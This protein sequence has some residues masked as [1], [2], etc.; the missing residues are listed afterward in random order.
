MITISATSLFCSYYIPRDWGTSLYG[1]CIHVCMC[2]FKGYGFLVILVRNRVSIL[3]ISVS[4]RVW[5]LHSSLEY[6]GTFFIRSYLFIIFDNTI[7]KN[8]SQ[9]FSI[10]LNWGTNY[11]AGLKQGIVL[12]V[13]S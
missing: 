5:F 8:S 9:Y 6:L 4:K 11:K 3:V 2:G 1:L 12:R 10:G 13:R 7:N